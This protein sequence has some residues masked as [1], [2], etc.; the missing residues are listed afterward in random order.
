MKKNWPYF[1]L[2]AIV[3]FVLFRMSE[4]AS[5]KRVDWKDNFTMS[6][7]NPYGCYIFDQYLGEMMGGKT[8]H[9]N[10]TAYQN[11]AGKKFTDHNY[12]FVNSDF[13]PSMQDVVNLV[14]FVEAGNDVLIS[15][16]DFG[17]LA[18]T[19][20]FQLGD[21]LYIDISKKPNNTT[22]G[23]MVNQGNA[24]VESNLVNPSL[25]LKKNASFDHT[26]YELAFTAFD[27]L[28]SIVLGQDGRGYAN[29]LRIPKGK[30]SFFIHTL[31]DAFGNYY[32][33]NANTVD[34][35]LNVVSYLP[36][37][38]TF[39]DTHYK[40]GRKENDDT[41][42]YIF[43]EPALRLGYVVL[44]IAGLIGFFLG[45][46]RRQRPVPVVTPP[47]NSTLEFVEQV[48]ALYYN[49]G[50][51]GDIVYKK[52]NYFLESVRSRFYVQTNVFDEKFLVRLENLSG[53]Q[54]DEVRQLFST[55]DYL[56]KAPGVSANELKRLEEQ[57]RNFNTKSKR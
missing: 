56:R 21:P 27:T 40:I 39:I 30:G 13:S 32:A 37:Q 43:S 11:L 52:I 4:K 55:I 38:E 25:H 8:D 35:L 2:L 10:L 15:A 42:R 50:N 29:Y 45:G 36:S 47:A 23:S 1:L 7:K 41:R 19:L 22:L 51:H 53:M 44:I 26:T 57:I 12:V 20:K 16:R 17:L 3:L 33:A 6:S 46:K 48:G 31:P 54:R 9:I 49:L 34:Y 14:K 28:R 24:F 5:A 18:D